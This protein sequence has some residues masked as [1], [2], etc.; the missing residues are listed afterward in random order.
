MLII[1]SPAK[2]QT[3]PE[4]PPIITSQ[5]PFKSKTRTLIQALKPLNTHDLKKL[6]SIS[7]S[8]AELNYQRFQLFDTEKFTLS[9]AAPAIFLFQ[10]DAYQSLNATT[11]SQRQ[12]EFAQDHL[13]LLSG[14]YGIL[15]PFDLIH[16][17]RLEMK[18]KL[19]TDQGD[20]LYEFWGNKI[21]KR[22][23]QYLST[24]NPL[25]V[26]LASTEYSKA[27]R[28]DQLEAPYVNIHFKQKNKGKFR[29]IGI[30]TKRA[31]GS[32]ARHL[33]CTKAK[34]I[35]SI[36]GFAENGYQYQDTISDETNLIF[37]QSE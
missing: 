14:L 37:H 22:I 13:V 35:R 6:M 5:I 31:R 24:S 12:L 8:I 28:F 16:P 7:E 20:N 25:L 30:L 10:G 1:L 2:R 21:T 4:N 34:T 36:K 17:Y 9:N 33:I 23:N 15:R 26:N 19:L 18:T 3:V 11:L 27:I 32:M 29:S